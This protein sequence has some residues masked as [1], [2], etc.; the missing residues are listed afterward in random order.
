MVGFTTGLGFPV[1]ADAFD[2]SAGWEDGFVCRLS[3]DLSRLLFSTFWG[4]SDTE[5]MGSIHFDGQDSIWVTGATH[6]YDYPI[7]EDAIQPYGSW[8]SYIAHF[9]IGPDSGTGSTRPTLLAPEE[10]AL[11]CYPNPFN[12]TAILQFTLPRSGSAQLLVYDLLG[13]KVLDENL[14]RLPAG[15]H[16]HTLDASDLS[17]GIYF[18]RLEALGL[19]R[20]QKMVIVR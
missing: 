20:V 9:Y 16:R 13:R 14:G 7:T 5:T 4:G 8:E 1:T 15:E 6:S 17:S 11:T 2:T 3:G 10:L 12:A 19:E 18:A